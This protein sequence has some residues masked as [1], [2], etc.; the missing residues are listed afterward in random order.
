[1]IDLIKKYELS[2]VCA[3]GSVIDP[4]KYDIIAHGEA[5]GRHERRLKPEFMSDPML[6][7]KINYSGVMTWNNGWFREKGLP[8]IIRRVSEAT[9]SWEDTSNIPY[10][11]L[12]YRRLR[13]VIRDGRLRPES[14]LVRIEKR[15][16]S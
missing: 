5:W 4:A 11:E 16:I 6:P 10:L 13:L 14:E 7:H 15:K 2:P 3:D 12:T 8:C 1:M 9:Y